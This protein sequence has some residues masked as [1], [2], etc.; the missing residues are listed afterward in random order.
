MISSLGKLLN[1]NNM[2]RNGMQA[3]IESRLS[4]N[5]SLKSTIMHLEDVVKNFYY[6]GRIL[7]SNKVIDILG[8][9][10]E[11]KINHSD[12]ITFYESLSGK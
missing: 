5:D 12:S 2:L 1:T 7:S 4:L 11:V 9:K 6:L 3:Y 8:T 10:G